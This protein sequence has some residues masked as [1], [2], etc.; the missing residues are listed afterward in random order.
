[1]AKVRKRGEEIRGFILDLVENNNTK[2]FPL[3]MDKFKISRQAVFQ[4]IQM[5]CIKK[6][7]IYLTTRETFGKIGAR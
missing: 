1:M 2:I 5:R 7:Q 6:T 4:H 3:T